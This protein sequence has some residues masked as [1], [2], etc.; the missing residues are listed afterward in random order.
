[1]KK[2]NHL[3]LYF[4]QIFLFVISIL[5][6]TN[7]VFSKD[8]KLNLPKDFF[9]Q[10]NF[11]NE[12]D[13]LTYLKYKNSIKSFSIS[14]TGNRYTIRFKFKTDLNFQEIYES[15]LME[16]NKY[17]DLVL[18][19]TID[20]L[21]KI[22]FGTLMYFFK[23]TYKGIEVENGYISIKYQNW[24][25]DLHKSLA[26]NI[27]LN[28]IPSISEEE[29][30]EF[31]LNEINAEKYCWEV[32]FY[33][34]RIKEVKNDSTATTYPKEVKLIIKE[35]ETIDNNIEFLLCY[36]FN[37]CAVQPRKRLQVDVNS[38]NGKV[39]EMK[40]LAAH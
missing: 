1:M 33:E 30:I 37:I 39:V 36:R 16:L 25:I 7:S 40:N 28:V 31:A 19:R 9:K 2:S 32:P 35:V 8:K 20:D 18:Y 29:A 24:F 10:N 15:Q 6:Y 23:Q 5:F 34:E 3:R 17:N 27:S 13:S 14:G 26:K 4:F 22:T 38:K 11:A 21:D 12:S